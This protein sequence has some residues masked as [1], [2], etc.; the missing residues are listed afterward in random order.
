MKA[1][2]TRP[3]GGCVRITVTVPRDLK[4]RMKAVRKVRVN[5]SGVAALAFERACDQLEA[6]PTKK[7]EG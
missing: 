7:V 1:V 3:A 2:P 5:W 6:T 4:R